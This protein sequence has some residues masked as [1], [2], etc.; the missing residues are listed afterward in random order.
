MK[1]K[2]R[3]SSISCPGKIIGMPGEVSMIAA[4]MV[5]AL[6]GE[7][8]LVVVGIDHA[9]KSALPRRMANL[10]VTLE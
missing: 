6:L 9:G 10:V 5:E 1:L 8:A 3:V 7:D 4:A 2:S